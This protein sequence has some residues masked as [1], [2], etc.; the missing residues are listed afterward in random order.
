M[1]HNAGDLD[2]DDDD[3][4]FSPAL[5][6]AAPKSIAKSAAPAAASTTTADENAMPTGE[7]PDARAVGY[8]CVNPSFESDAAPREIFTVLLAALHKHDITTK[9]R[10]DWTVRASRVC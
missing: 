3:A 2:D 9:T 8:H 6:L 7:V 1:T 5:V 10:A 4:I